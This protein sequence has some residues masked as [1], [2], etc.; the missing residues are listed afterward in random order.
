[1]NEIWKH[2]TNLWAGLLFFLAISSV[3]VAVLGFL[4]ERTL[5][6]ERQVDT[7]GKAV[8][9]AHGE[10]KEAQRTQRNPYYLPDP[11]KVVKK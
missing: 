4:A 2:I 1:M 8:K 10:A 3:I 7:L 9:A 6:L 11:L 5:Q